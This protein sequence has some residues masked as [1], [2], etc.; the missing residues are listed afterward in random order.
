M[1]CKKWSIAELQGP[2][3]DV[4]GDVT[5]ETV[6]LCGEFEAPP[7]EARPEAFGGS[8]TV[9]D[10][11]RKISSR[12]APLA[13]KAVAQKI[14][15][16]FLASTGTRPPATPRGS[17]ATPGVSSQ[18]AP[19]TPAPAID[20][21]GITERRRHVCA[22]GEHTHVNRNHTQLRP[23]AHPPPCMPP[24]PLH[25][26]TLAAAPGQAPRC[27]HGTARRCITA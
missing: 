8:S 3:I 19:R 5:G 9:E 26:A 20:T 17:P 24:A 23:A 1:A 14:V 27:A 16:H 10:S 2:S 13:A 15:D 18:A 7:F 6:E 25:L 22:T 21:G 11:A 4:Q 12:R